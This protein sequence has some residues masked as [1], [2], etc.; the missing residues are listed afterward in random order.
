MEQRK[1]KKEEEE[2]EE[3]EKEKRGPDRRWSN[4]AFNKV[5]RMDGRT[6]GPSSRP[7]KLH[8]LEI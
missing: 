3:E 7:L 5:R 6:D 1:N 2:E 8:D 4:T